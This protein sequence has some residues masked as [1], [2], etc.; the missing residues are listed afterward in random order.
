MTDAEKIRAKHSSWD[1]CQ[2]CREGEPCNVVRL[3]DLLEEWLHTPYFATEEEWREWVN[4][5]RPR[6]ERTLREVAGGDDE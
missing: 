4:E 2:D 3:A 1:G 5:F 6:V